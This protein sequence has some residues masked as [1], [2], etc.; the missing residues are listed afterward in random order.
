MD[1]RSAI[2]ALLAVPLVV[3]AQY[4]GVPT[5]DPDNAPNPQHKKKPKPHTTLD[6]PSYDSMMIRD[7]EYKIPLNTEIKLG[8][9]YRALEYSLCRFPHPPLKYTFGV[10]KRRSR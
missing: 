4:N 1:R 7:N 5:Y 2:L 10:V 3:E 6:L 8:F 9:F